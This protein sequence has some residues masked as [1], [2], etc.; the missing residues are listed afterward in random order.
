LLT[1]FL[2]KRTPQYTPPRLPREALVQI[3]CHQHAIFG[4]KEEQK[5]LN[6]LG[7]DAEILNTGCCGMAGSFGFET[8]KFAL[9]RQIAQR[10]LVPKIKQSPPDTLVIANGFSCQ[11]QIKQETKRKPLHIAQVMQLALL[12]DGRLAAKRRMQAATVASKTR[13]PPRLLLGLSLGLVAAGALTM[14]WKKLTR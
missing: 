8:E 11:T 7:L 5:I 9:S 6:D 3:H 2:A 14:T 12:H 4:E 10:G 1:E 13:K